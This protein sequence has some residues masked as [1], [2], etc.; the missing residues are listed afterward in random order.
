MTD[1]RL[2]RELHTRDGGKIMLVVV[3]GLGGL[4][5]EA[6]GPTELEAAHTPNLDR[7]AAEG[8]TG[9]LEIVQPGITP[10][11][12]A[13]HLALFGYDPLTQLVDRGV[14]AALGIQFPLEEG[15]VA[16]RGNFCTVGDDG[17]VT[18][19]RAGRPSSQE[20]ARLVAKLRDHVDL[21]GVEAMVEPVKEH[22]FV[23]VLRDRT[24]EAL[25]ADVTD[26]DPH[27]PGVRPLDPEGRTP[28]S[29]R[30]A[31]LVARFVAQAREALADEDRANMV[32]LRGIAIRPD[33]PDLHEA[34]GLTACAVA[35]YPMYRGLA[36]LLG[37][38]LAPAPD[39][40]GQA[41]GLVADHWDDH[42]FFFVHHKQTD[43]RGEDG[44][45][46]AKVAELERLDEAMPALVDLQPDVLVV[47]GDHSTP[48]HLASH[49][50]HP[51]PM[52]LH[53]AT[54]RRDGATAFGERACMGGGLGRR[55]AQDLM[56]LALA[57]AGRLTKYG[58]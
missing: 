15:D 35:G 22:R 26:T 43:S 38:T 6:G 1:Q 14:L 20:G 54:A 46:D 31:D 17:L 39:H 30:T 34:Y 52:L 42:D 41:A 36:S 27:R 24:G 16:A 50:W 23:L 8:T 9:M 2:L 57:H 56:A 51:V 25:G 21:A 37:M 19:R 3:D 47:T 49:S 44:D 28:G 48:A 18:D 45:F 11:S 53:A 33:L 13:G 4:E 7:L 5:R 40:I 10:G 58:A 32:L 55:P 29:R 12:G